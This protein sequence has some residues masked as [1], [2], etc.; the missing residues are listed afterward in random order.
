MVHEKEDKIYLKVGNKI[1]RKF[2][3]TQGT[4]ESDHQIH[5]GSYHHALYEANIEGFN[6][7]QYSSILPSIAT[8]VKKPSREELEKILFEDGQFGSEMNTIMACSNTD[9]SEKVTAGMIFGWLYDIKTGVKKGG[10]VCEYNGH[11]NEKFVKDNLNSCL[12]ELYNKKGYKDVFRLEPKEPIIQSFE[13]KKKYGSVLIAM[14]FLDYVV[15][16]FSRID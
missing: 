6:I 16:Y 11:D 14:C 8:E 1:P 10:L 9:K 7:K 15:P 3:I 2:F 13:P 5:A 12:E 4:G